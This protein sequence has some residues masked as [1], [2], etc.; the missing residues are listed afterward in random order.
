MPSESSTSWKHWIGFGVKSGGQL[1]IG[2]VESVTAYMVNLGSGETFDLEVISSRWGLGLG[3]SGN[4]IV[5]LGWGFIEP[6]E[7]DGKHENDW[8]FNIAFT[9]KLVSK[10][11]IKAIT[12]SKYFYDM[13][14]ANKAILAYRQVKRAADGIELIET[15][16]N[17]LHTLFAGFQ[18][19]KPEGVVI[20][21][22]PAAGAGVEVS[23]YKSYGT[24]YVSNSSDHDMRE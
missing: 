16:R 13:Y 12:F 3:G 7:L 5:V 17:A 24:M 10:S 11:A 4:A 19:H 6:Y 14:K 23:A 18:L 22:V 9:E 2:G 15:M 8:G 21:E 1:G 20:V